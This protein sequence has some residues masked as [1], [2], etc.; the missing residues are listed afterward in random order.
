MLIKNRTSFAKG[1]VMT[2][3]F[4][5]VLVTMFMPI[6]EGE[7]AFRAADK[8]FN[9]IS[10]GST[11]YVPL[12]EEMVAPHDDGAVDGPIK[13][14]E[15]A[16]ADVETVFAKI[17]ANVSDRPDGLNVDIGFEALFDA[18]LGDVDDMFHNRGEKVSARYGIPEKRVLYAW[19]NGLRGV[20]KALSA[21]KRFTEAKVMSEVLD[22]GVAVGYNYYKVE[23]QKAADR[24]SILTFALVFYVA[25]TLWWGFA[26]YF[27]FE[28]VGLQLTAGKKKEV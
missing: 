3:V 25:Y 22:R 7:N 10:K 16:R 9:T 12:L 13:L 2:V 17:G 21:E 20:E 18:V 28:G 27:L 6:F 5:A 14:Q 1:M 24:W 4:V 8:L 19:W 26:V 15:G 23:P 11:Y